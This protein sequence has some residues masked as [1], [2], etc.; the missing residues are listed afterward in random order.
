MD[1]FQIKKDF[2]DNSILICFNGPFSHNIL[3][4]IGT[5]IRNYL[6]NENVAR[7]AVSDVFSIYI[8]LTQNARNYIIERKMPPGELSS[9]IVVVARNQDAHA[10]TAGNYIRKEDSVSLQDRV[11]KVNGLNQQ[12]LKALYKEQ[13]R[14]ESLSSGAG[15][16]LIDVARKMTS[17]MQVDIKP[18][19]D[20]YSFFSLTAIVDS[21][22]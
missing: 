16:G 15:V 6:N 21:K 22:E 5:A 3:E 14:S 9:T 19:D 18:I 8:E 17:P 7:A 20:T 12:E 2:N 4:E 1:V 11:N 13:L 10:I